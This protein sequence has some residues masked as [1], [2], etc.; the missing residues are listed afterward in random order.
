MR[1][2]AEIETQNRE[3]WLLRACAEAPERREGWVELSLYYHDQMRW[4]ACLAASKRALEIT[5]KPLEYLCEEPAWGSLPHD[6]AAVSSYNLG[7]VGEAE[8][9][10]ENA[11]SYAPED[12]RLLGNLEAY[13]AFNK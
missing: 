11:V 12:K 10:G 13:R 7:L 4:E 2:I 9:H 6:L 3:Q 1:Y 8:K 5:E